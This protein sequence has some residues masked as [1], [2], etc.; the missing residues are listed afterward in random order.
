MVE[1]SKAKQAL[2]DKFRTI[3]AERL[4]KLNRAVLQVEQGIVDAALG[5]EIMREIHTLKG[6]AKLVGFG[7]I[8]IVAHRTEALLIRSRDK[9]FK[10]DQILSDT[11]FAGLDLAGVLITEAPEMSPE[12]P[13]VAAF[14]ERADAVLGGRVA[15]LEAEPTRASQ[16]VQAAADAAIAAMD[17]NTRKEMERRNAADSF[18]RLRA[19]TSIRVDIAKLNALTELAGDLALGQARAERS[20]KQIDEGKEQWKDLVQALRVELLRMG[21]SG[22]TQGTDVAQLVSEVGRRVAAQDELYA[23]MR[24]V[25]VRAQED[26]FEHRMRL[27]ELENRLRDLRLLPISSLFEPYPR[28]VRDL[29]RE[30]DKQVRVD[31][32]GTDVELDKHVLDEINEPLLHLV[33]NSVD[34]GIE[35]PQERVR[36]GKPE[37]GTLRLVARQR[38]AMV[39]IDIADDG[40]GIDPSV[41][42]QVAVAKGIL[43]ADAAG[44][45]SDDDALALVFR[46]GFSTRMEVTDIS[47]RG[48]GLDVVK[49]RLEALGGSVRMQT[50][51]GTGTR[52]LLS[53]PISVILT[54]VLVV[55]VGGVRYAVPA[56]AVHQATYV[57]PADIETAGSGHAFVLD[58]ER[59]PIVDLAFLLGANVAGELRKDFR[60]VV[61]LQ[62]EDLKLGLIVDSFVGERQVVQRALN[63]F[64]DGLRLFGGSAVLEYGDVALMLNV[65]EVLQAAGEAVSWRLRG[66]TTVEA[67]AERTVLV[68]DD[69][70]MTR[71]LIVGILRAHGLKVIE[72][73][74]GREAVDRAI[75]TPPDLL[76]T[77]LEM[78][79][80]DGFG[81][82][83]EVRQSS[84]LRDLPVIVFT[85]R[86]SAADKRQAADLGANAYLVKTE[87][88]EEDLL[89]AVERFLK[90]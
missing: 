14:L 20:L 75:E 62:L 55:E 43:E 71:D 83:R 74:N 44:R 17:V 4:E 57:S 21:R 16:E 12:T 61:V 23:I 45:M 29:A 15:A 13:Y 73:V 11:I 34:H 78:P 47:G 51:V 60:S 86:G 30:Q 85:T 1:R 65:A 28:A 7:A 19:E 22:E 33:R 3:T 52:F 31:V 25:L 39:E 49:Q 9:G 58:G 79:V 84:A 37:I 59:I 32:Q 67:A 90:R 56:E 64:L 36:A 72:A 53:V 80:L 38:G 81:V 18:M 54:R 27:E 89:Q 5:E 41:V 69:S 10:L 46:A 88:R 70:E 63:K 48:V 42:R 82:L 40:R 6:E 24:G 50:E 8:N 66:S 26:Q 76:L 2:V 68:A 87:F 35:S 77:D